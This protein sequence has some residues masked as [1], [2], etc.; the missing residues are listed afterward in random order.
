M[1]PHRPL[2]VAVASNVFALGKP[3][4]D[5]M[6][7]IQVTPDGEFRAIDG[8]PTDVPAWRMNAANAAQVI[9]L[10]SARI[11]PIVI[12]YEHQTLNK[13]KNGQ[14][15][16]AAAWFREFE[17]RPGAGLFA[18]V[19]LTRRA[20][21]LIEDEELGYFSPVF[22]YDTAGNVVEMLMGGFTNTP[23]IDGMQALAAAAS[24]QLSTGGH[25][26]S[27]TQKLALTAALCAALSIPEDANEAQALQAINDLKTA[28]T[29]SDER[30]AALTAQQPDPSKFV[31]IETFNQLQTQ[32]AALN[33]QQTDQAVAALVA[34]AE[35][36]TDGQ[37]KVTAATKDWFTAFAKKD[38]DGARA[39]LKDAP[40][41]AALS[42]MQSGGHREVPNAADADPVAVAA[43]AR[44][45]Q[46]DQAKAGITVSTAAAVDHVTKNKGA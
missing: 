24:A 42:R 3:D 25:I 10:A 11:T 2:A 39:W 33:Q 26:V 21:Q 5:G 22:G 35:G 37:V 7:T 41:I 27:Q 34:Q 18:R 4:T 32:V 28:K 45:Y 14:P 13:E 30:V 1:Q 29:T 16:P 8:R 17:Y 38:L 44:K 23:A 36:E 12:D 31:P 15:A 46:D 6:L 19:K 40:V 43:L 20:V 9:A